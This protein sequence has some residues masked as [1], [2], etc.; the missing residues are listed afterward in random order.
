MSEA[1]LRAGAVAT[2]PLLILVALLYS[3]VREQS[4]TAALLPAR[5]L[6]FLHVMKTGGLSLDELLNCVCR[7]SGLCTMLQNE[8]C[9]NH[10]SC[11]RLRGTHCG[12]EVHASV[13]STHGEV[14][15]L[16][17]HSGRSGVVEDTAG[18]LQPAASLVAWADATLIITILRHPLERV[19]SFYH[20]ERRW[21]VP[22]QQEPL[23][24]FLANPALDPNAHWNLT[25]GRLGALACRFCAQQLRN[26]MVLQFATSPALLNGSASVKHLEEASR[27][28][29]TRVAAIAFTAELSALVPWLHTHWN[30]L[31][32]HSKRCPLQ[33]HNADH[34]AVHTATRPD[35][36]I[37]ATN[38][39]D[40][41]LWERANKMPNAVHL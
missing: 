14:R 36:L 3:T 22:Y 21:Y 28:L 9:R 6:L 7:G 33:I 10:E 25:A 5:S 31:F 1:W 39:F 35:R 23:D 12:S 26:R 18:Y 24:F 37:T 4:C 13:R 40:T 8:G 41:I 16:L 34:S 11:N 19:W 29:A 17:G 27:F 2:L 32:Q 30:P 20:Y 15:A 38:A